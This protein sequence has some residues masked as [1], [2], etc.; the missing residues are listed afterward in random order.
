[1]RITGGQTIKVYRHTK[2]RFGDKV[3][4]TYVGD[5][6]HCVLQWASSSSVGLRFHP[7][8]D[9]EESFKLS[10]VIFCPRDAAIK[11]EPRD[12]FVYNGKTY[13]VA[14]ERAWDQLNPATGYDYGYYMIQV[15]VVH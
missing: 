12:R 11:L 6:E 4:E 2:D 5:I 15:E 1:M 10:A 9:F 14:G 13:Q 7:S 8:N 3:G